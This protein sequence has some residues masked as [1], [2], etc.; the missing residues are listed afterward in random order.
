VAAPSIT[1]TVS[2][3]GVGIRLCIW[4]Q[5]NACG[6]GLTCVGGSSAGA[7]CLTEFSTTECPG[8]GSCTANLQA[9][10]SPGAAPTL[11]ASLLAADNT[12]GELLDPTCTNL[13]AHYGSAWPLLVTR[14]LAD[15][16]VPVAIVSYALGGALIKDFLPGGVFYTAAVAHDS[17]DGGKCEAVIFYQGESNSSSKI[18]QGGAAVGTTCTVDG[19]CP[20]STCAA[21]TQSYFQTSLAAIAAGVNTDLSAPF[22]PVQIGDL[23]TGTQ[24]AAD[25]IRLAA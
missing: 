19:D 11:K 8:G 7:G 21:T 12:W 25:D 15:Q 9:Y 17:V 22:F 6:T 20:S 16:L 24:Y 10:A 1:A 14:V 18:C 4:G 2:T 5:S 13:G 3:I 23:G